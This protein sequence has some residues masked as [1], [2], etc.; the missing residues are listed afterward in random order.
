MSEDR[1]QI[2]Q[3]VRERFSALADTASKDSCCAPQEMCCD[4]SDLASNLYDLELI[5]DMPEE[6]SGFSLGCGD[7]V[8]LANLEPGQVVVDLGSG[9]GLDCFLA[10]R[11]VGD[12]GHVIGID[13]TDEMLK[14]AEANRLKTGLKNVEFRKGHIESLP[15]DTN[16]V[17]V[18]LSNCVI[19]LSPDKAAVF[20]E[21]YRI[22]K[23]DGRLAISDMVTEG[24]FSSELQADLDGWAACVTGAVDLDKYLEMIRAAGFSEIRVVDKVDAIEGRADFPKVFSV[25]VE[26]KK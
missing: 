12:Q 8:T 10:A 21:A 13:M 3:A 18:I 17:D 15:V 19:N 11:V 25:R 7:P 20:S 26:A 14:L 5:E 24:D 2:H 23:N 1:D 4:P 22:L 6:I 16:T 9:G